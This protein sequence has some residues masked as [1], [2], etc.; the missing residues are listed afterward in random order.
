MVG[1]SASLVVLALSLQLAAREG[2]G[3][4]PLLVTML[5]GCI[6]LAGGVIL[7][8][9]LVH[10]AVRLAERYMTDMPGKEKLSLMLL[11]LRDGDA[12][13]RGAAVAVSALAAGVLA[14]L[15]PLLLRVGQW[16]RGILF[17][18]FVWS[19]PALAVLDFAF[20]VGVLAAPMFVMGCVL[21]LLDRYATLTARGDHAVPAGA[22]AGAVIGAA[23]VTVMAT[24]STGP[25][26]V[27]AAAPLPLLMVAAA[28]GW[29]MM[30][31]R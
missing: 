3:R 20:A 22:A 1:V 27:L 16:V 26:T 10:L 11:P 17:D 28:A 24:S 31:H 29:R 15:I 18:H 8:R 12:T 25:A 14:A 5:A 21:T 13:F 7:P 2:D 19:W 30:R 4:V 6:V 9:R 23:M